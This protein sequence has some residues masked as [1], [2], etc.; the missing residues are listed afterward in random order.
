[1]RVGTILKAESQKNAE[2]PAYHFEIDFGKLGIKHS[3][4]QVT[5]IYKPEELVGRQII[6]VINFLPKRIA[7]LSSEVLVMGAY[8]SQNEVV[9]IEP[10]REMPNGSK[11][12]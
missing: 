11:I 9:L 7:G 10:H 12:G 1:M 4:A 2:N 8:G 5:D 6:A 3:S